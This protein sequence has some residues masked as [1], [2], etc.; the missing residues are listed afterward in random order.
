MDLLTVYFYEENIEVSS[1]ELRVL[2]NR[3]SSCP[4]ESWSIQQ[5]IESS[6][7]TPGSGAPGPSEVSSKELRVLETWDCNC[8]T[9]WEVSSKELREVKFYGTKL[10][11]FF[12]SIQQGIESL[13]LLKANSK[14]PAGSIQ[15]GIEREPDRDTGERDR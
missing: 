4:T 9:C 13:L 2:I 12:G 14:R 5:G 3:F 8:F 1:K 15:Q 7:R 6:G 11:M 10:A